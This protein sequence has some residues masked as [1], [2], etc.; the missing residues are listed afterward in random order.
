[1]F[2][3][4]IHAIWSL[5]MHCVF[6]DFKIIKGLYVSHV[7][8][9]GAIMCSYVSHLSVCARN[10]TAVLCTICVMCLISVATSNHI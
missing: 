6:V 8:I 4:C 1:M 10:F 5:V 9:E 3:P 2:F 7:H